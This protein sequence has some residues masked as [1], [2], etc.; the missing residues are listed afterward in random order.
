[1]NDD[2]T[3]LT[4]DTVRDTEK[5]KELGVREEERVGKF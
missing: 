5:V 1:M 4:S 3:V 2:K